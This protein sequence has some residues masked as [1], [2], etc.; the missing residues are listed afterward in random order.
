MKIKLLLQL[1]IILISFTGIAQTTLIPDINFEQALINEGHEIGPP[2]GSIETWR[3]ESITLLYIS[4]YGI[5]DL[6]GIEDFTELMVLNVNDNQLTSLNLTNHPY[7]T[8]LYSNNNQLTNINISGC[9]SLEVLGCFG[10]QLNS[11]NVAQ[12]INLKDIT[13]R[14]NFITDLDVTNNINLEELYVGNNQLTNL[15]LTQNTSLTNFLCGGNELTNLDLSQNTSLE[16]FACPNNELLTLNVKNGNNS[17][18]T[19]FDSLNNPSLACIQVDNEMDANNNIFPYNTWTKDGFATYSENCDLGNDDELLGKGL[20]LFP[21]PVKSFIN[22]ELN[23]GI[24]LQKVIIYN[25]L[26]Q[27][28][29]ST[30]NLK[31]NT[32]NLTSGVY[33]LKVE[34]NMGKSTKKMVVE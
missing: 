13:C 23:Q 19:S 26:G 32:S 20:K 12:N 30:K 22:I 33:F 21:N 34:T 10:N 17:L 25:A 6:T 8:Y 29:S 4:N 2:D 24:E 31:I 5:T 1:L 18:L 28:V 16:W 14:D 9:Q 15:D 7:L 3:A 11:L 27:F